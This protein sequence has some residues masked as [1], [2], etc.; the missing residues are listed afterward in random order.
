MITTVEMFGCKCNNCGKEWI[1]NYN[2]FVAFTDKLGMM[3][4]ISDDEMWYSDNYKNIH[5]C[6]ECFSFSDD[7][8]LMLK[9][10]SH[11]HCKCGNLLEQPK[12][13]NFIESE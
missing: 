6:P 1:D 13:F 10:M 4:N 8:E 5:Y 11:L 7:D 2:S 12:G 9:N 3:N